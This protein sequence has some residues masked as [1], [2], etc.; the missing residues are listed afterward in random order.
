[1][2]L[3]PRADVPKSLNSCISGPTEKHGVSEPGL[4]DLS[5]DLVV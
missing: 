5:I 2:D 3:K 4:S 1:M